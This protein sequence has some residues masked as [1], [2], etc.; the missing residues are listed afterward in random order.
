M[1][2]CHI[3]EWP[4]NILF[5]FS[6]CHHLNQ[7]LENIFF[8][9]LAEGINPL[10]SFCSKWMSIKRAAQCF[11][12]RLISGL[13]RKHSTKM[14]CRRSKKLYAEFSAKNNNF[15]PLFFH[16]NLI[17]IHIRK[18]LK[19]T[20]ARIKM[21]YSLKAYLSYDKWPLMKYSMKGNRLKHCRFNGLSCDMALW[22]WKK[23]HRF[24]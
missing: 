21:N 14:F 15:F 19:F 2:L 24:R 6:I 22:G 20:T 12:E 23:I 7:G 1:T 4:L 11:S 17:N 10:Q 16:Q 5:S 8:S 13:E 3:R 18:L 9:R